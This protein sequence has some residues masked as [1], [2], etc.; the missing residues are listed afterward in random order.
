[1]PLSTTSSLST[2]SLESNDSNNYQSYI[3]K[4]EFLKIA[5]KHKISILSTNCQ[6]YT[7]N[8]NSITELILELEPCVLAMQELFQPPP[9]ILNTEHY[10]K[11]IYQLRAKGKGG[12]VGI[13]VRKGI[14]IINTNKYEHLELSHIEAVSCTISVEKKHLI[15]I[16]IYKPP[17]KKIRNSMDELQQILDFH[18]MSNA[19]IYL[20]GDFNIDYFNINSTSFKEYSTLLDNNFLTQ[21]ISLP[22]RVTSSSASTIDHILCNRPEI[23]KPY[24]L[25]HCTADHQTIAGVL[26]EKSEEKTAKNLP[27][28]KPNKNCIL[29]LDKTIEKLESL[30]WKEIN[31]K[32]ECST[33]DEGMQYLTSVIQQNFIHKK[34]KPYKQII[35][36]WFSKDMLKLRQKKDKLRAKFLKNR[37]ETNEQNFKT[38]R[39]QY[40]MKVKNIKKDYY[41]NKIKNADN[42]SKKI[43]QTINEILGRKVKTTDDSIS[44]RNENNDIISEPNAVASMFNNFYIEFAPDLASKIPIPKITIEDLLKNV[45]RPTEVF[46]YRP[47]PEEEILEIIKKTK[48]KLSSGADNISGKLILGIKGLLTKPLT[49]IINKGYVEKAFPPSKKI[50]KLTPIHKG[51]DKNSA[52]L[53]RPINQLPEFSK[54]TERAGLLQVSDFFKRNNVISQ[55]QFGFKENNSTLHP[56]IMTKNCIE[57]HLN[58]KKYVILVCIDLKSAFDTCETKKI[59]PQ[60][61]QHYNFSPEATEYTG[62]FFKNR[63]QFINVNNVYSEVKDLK[64]ISVVQGSSSGPK[65][66][67]VLINDLVHNTSFEPILFADDT[68]L[69]MANSDISELEKQ[70][71]IELEKIQAFMQCN[72]LTLNLKKTVYLLFTPKSK[73]K[74]P[75]T[76]T[77]KNGIETIEIEE[78]SEVK[79]LGVWIDSALKFQTQFNNVISKMRSGLSALYYVKHDLPRHTKKLI[80]NSLIKP[81]YE[82]ATCIWASNLTKGQMKEIITLQKRALR[83]IYMQHS[84]SHTSKLFSISGITRFDHLFIK[85]TLDLFHKTDLDLT[86]IAIKE[87][88]DSCKPIENPRQQY[89]FNRKIPHNFKSGNLIYKIVSTWNSLPEYMKQPI[90]GKYQSKKKIKNYI[91]SLYDN[92]KCIKKECYSCNVTTI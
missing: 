66:F 1:M 45:P 83:L 4:T 9:S 43:W 38:F 11:P 34:L 74:I 65:F 70:A 54:I 69:I 64:D 21:L 52:V 92:E 2:F 10:Q 26:F 80:F 42:N 24:V 56:L 32:I 28:P 37:T 55:N 48:P 15:V 17:N 35:K 18:A 88:L 71:N 58:S 89:K 44:L 20:T 16:C 41:H 76:L 61:L 84:K 59:L 85:G 68:N 53:Y 22:T 73:P 23:V 79:F 78:K 47:H 90:T 86:P 75:I 51:G 30:N 57:N 33:S 60:K 62:S 91:A 14:E 40:Y 72:K 5:K 25:T 13:L 49:T 82:Y 6:S 77:L 87:I 63:K 36:P 67:N 12:G 39:N 7:A 50:S 27:E 29:D 3:S 8:H 81:H 31:S 46:N 19:T